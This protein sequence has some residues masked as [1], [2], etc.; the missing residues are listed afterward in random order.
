M[1]DPAS[2]LSAT[3]NNE[4]SKELDLRMRRLYRRCARAPPEIHLPA[5]ALVTI[6]KDEARSIARLLDSVRGLVDEMIVVDTGSTD[7]TVAIARA[8]GG[9][10][11]HFD[12]VDDFA[13]ARNFAL[14]QTQMPWRLV[15]DADEWLDRETSD[16]RAVCTE[17]ATFVGRIA[18]SDRFD[19]DV[20]GRRETLI[21]RVWISRLLPI[22]VTYAG[23]IHEQV[24]HDLPT[25][26]VP[27]HAF[28]DGYEDRQL[29]RKGDRNLEILA[30][31]ADAG[32]SDA[33]LDYQYAREL[34]RKGDLAAAA[35]RY[36]KSLSGIGTSDTPWREGLICASL[37][38][39][40]R[41]RAFDAA[42]ELIER[43][44]PAYA[45]SADFWF[46]V[47]SFLMDAAQANPQI[48]AQFLVPIENAFL[49]CLEI[50]E[51]DDG[52][53]GVIGRGSFLAAQNLR[54]LYVATGRDAKA[55]EYA[56]L[57][58]ITPESHKN[59]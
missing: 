2:A 34:E 29:A 10:V 58:T 31:L 37:V 3:T 8:A 47:G 11:S 12:W 43:E 25:R 48:G 33:Y 45:N 6:V 4:V 35:E 59:S 36:A 26:M 18:R 55:A 13:A 17:P 38:T 9:K 5:V 53:E 32:R 42:F 19:S 54:A 56:A 16:L 39:F 49:R 22:G 57:A 52:G 1:D 23:A 40:G 30:Q 24:V 46:C 15:L 50:G 27:L 21:S 44:T 14:A 20:A 7:D 51:R 41:V 28:H